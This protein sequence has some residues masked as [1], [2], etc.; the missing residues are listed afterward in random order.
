MITPEQVVTDYIQK[1][2]EQP[3]ALQVLDFADGSTAAGR[4]ARSG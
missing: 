1:L 2:V 4:L 3:G